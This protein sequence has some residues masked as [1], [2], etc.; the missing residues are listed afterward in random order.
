MKKV[1]NFLCALDD[2][3]CI[4]DSDGCLCFLY[5]LVDII[6]LLFLITAS[7]NDTAVVEYSCVKRM[8]GWVLLALSIK[9]SKVSMPCGHIR[10]MS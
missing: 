2:S 6:I 1:Y 9:D 5:E 4:G 8:F 3:W 10:K 7:M